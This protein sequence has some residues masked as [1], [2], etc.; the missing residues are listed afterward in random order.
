MHSRAFKDGVFEQFARV[1]GGFDSP[2]RL[3]LIDLLVQGPRAVD[4][5]AR[6]TG[7]TVANTSRHL[8]Q[9]RH[10]GLVTSTREAQHI[11][12]EISDPKV[13]DAYRLLREVA[14]ARL[15]EV[16]HLANAFFQESDGAEPVSLSHLLER[17]RAGDVL[18]VDVRPQEEF[19]AGHIPGAINIPLTELA[20]RLG[21]LPANASIAA[22]CRGPYCV[23]SAEA[24]RQMRAA[25]HDAR[26]IDGGVDDWRNLGQPI[27]TGSS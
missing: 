25:G 19:S 22:Y 13:C 15:A 4:A 5:L 1:A 6:L 3:E 24:V 16:R 8:Q 14:E 20:S 18:V 12:Y 2:K 9:L 7:M 10:S 21:E 27:V 26:R 23:L 11:V 17:A